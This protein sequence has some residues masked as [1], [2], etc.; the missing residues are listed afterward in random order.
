[1]PF[2]ADGTEQNTTKQ[3]SSPFKSSF[4]ADTTPEKTPIANPFVYDTS[5]SSVFGKIV[6]EPINALNRFGIGLGTEIGKAGLGLGETALKSFSALTGKST[7][8]QQEQIRNIKS[9]VFQKP[10]EEETSTLTG[11]VGALTGKALPFIATG[12]AV[13]KGQEF[14][15]G[16]TEGIGSGKVVP[17]L[18][19][20]FA[21]VAPEAVVSGGTEYAISGG[22]KQSAIA[23]GIGAGVL[24]G[25]THVGSDI[26][27]QLIPQDVKTNVLKSL[28]MTGKVNLKDAATGKK[29]NDGVEAYTTISRLAPD[30][31]V[32]DEYGVE[33]AF[34]P[35]K[36][37]NIEM[38]QALYQAKNKIY[39]AY[40][41]LASQL[42][43]AGAK[44]TAKDFYSVIDDLKKYDGAG[45]TPAYSRKANEIIESLQRFVKTGSRGQ[46]YFADTDLPAIQGLVEKINVDVN[47]LSDKA[48]AQ[49]AQEASQQI[50][51]LLDSKIESASGA[52]YQ[53][54]RNAYAQ[55]KSIEPAVINNFKK[56]ARGSKMSDFINGVSV[57]DTLTG[58]ITQDPTQIVRGGV[59]KGVKEGITYLGSSEA[60]MRRAFKLINQ[61]GGQEVTNRLTGAIAK[62]G[63]AFRAGQGAQQ[64]I[65]DY[66]ENPK[67]GLSAEDVSK[68]F[69]KEIKTY[70]KNEPSF[71][72]LGQLD[73]YVKAFDTEFKEL[74]SGYKNKNE[75]IGQIRQNIED[76]GVDTSKMNNIDIAQFADNVTRLSQETPKTRFIQGA[77]G[78]FAGSQSLASDIPQAYKGEKDLTTK[79]LK[80]LEGKTTVSKQYILDSTNRPELKQQERDL[81]RQALE[82]EGNTVNVNDFAKKVKAE[83]LPLKVNQSRGFRQ[84]PGEVGGTRYESITLP[85]DVRGNVKNYTENVYESPIKTSAGDVHF[86]GTSKPNYFGHTRIEDMVDNKTRRVIE[87]QSDLYQ[88]GN[89]EKELGNRGLGQKG[90]EVMTGEQRATQR[91]NDVAK[92]QQYND[93]TAHFRMVREEIKKAAQD[94]KTKLQF[95]TGETAM[96]IEGLGDNTHWYDTASVEKIRNEGGG[97]ADL[98]RNATLSPEKLVV[99]KEITQGDSASKW[100]ITDVLGDGK[101]KAIPKQ[102]ITTDT[103]K[104]L[105][106]TGKLE[107]T[108]FTEGA[109]EQFDISGKV[110]TNNPI[111]KFYEKDMQKYL[112]KFGG[113]R[114]VDN[115]GVSWFEIPIKKEQGKLPVEAFGIAGLGIGLGAMQNNNK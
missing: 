102:N 20:K 94:G 29:L 74:P 4:I 77:D 91:K 86:S 63:Q 92:L 21:Q 9:N 62:E 95:P 46:K 52:G 44:F 25:I 69:S 93:P 3:S 106:K 30:I 5:G 42:G 48:G 24:S 31:K 34:D 113:K 97:L 104:N 73:E 82:S 26:Y 6:K 65:K 76:L 49:V 109:V 13:T 17:Y 53:Q 81:I 83:L 28:G 114:V 23:T 96:K 39:Q 88:K 85:S 15:T 75:F 7:Q 66:A 37:T 70:F 1:M 43:D 55:L 41:D 90:T 111:Y 2:I 40:S 59:I 10:Y 60:A 35:T 47:P 89:L 33:K 105:Q 16:A 58:L 79:I 57:V 107:G 54:L 45:Y 99:G 84:R 32:V 12:G 98:N 68:K 64:A 61:G 14:L 87:V 80:D 100:I 115:K 103:L 22:D 38:P 56:A 67:L 50:R 71:N 78:K 36:A 19:Q 8:P 51:G 101:F 27:R 110:D 72:Q 18:I 11:G 112:N 108:G